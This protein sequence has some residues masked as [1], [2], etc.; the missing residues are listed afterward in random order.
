MEQL[1]EKRRLQRINVTKS[2]NRVAEK[3]NQ[4]T[5]AEKTEQVV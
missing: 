2:I 1:K 4:F 3:L 5:P